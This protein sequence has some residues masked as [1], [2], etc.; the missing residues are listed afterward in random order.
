V[1]D[2]ESVDSVAFSQIRIVEFANPLSIG[3]GFDFHFG[4]IRCLVE[5]IQK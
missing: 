4:L 5:L 1:T 3:F 2:F